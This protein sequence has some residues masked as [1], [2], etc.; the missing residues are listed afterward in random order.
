M[1]TTAKTLL[2]FIDPETGPITRI[3]SAPY[4]GLFKRSWWH[5]SAFLHKK[6]TGVTG[7]FKIFNQGSGGGWSPDKEESQVKAVVEAIERWSFFY[8]SSGQSA[9]LDIDSTTNGFA[10]LPDSFGSGPVKANA[11]CEALERWLLDRIWYNGD[12]FL[13]NFPWERTKAAALFGGHAKRLRVY[14]TET[15]DMEFPALS[16]KKVFFCL[17]LLETEYGGVLPG[18]ACGVDVNAVAEHAIIELYNHNL[19]FGKIKKLNPARLDSLIEA[20]LYY[21]AGSKSAG[22][23]VKAKIQI[24]R[25]FI[26]KIPELVFSAAITGPWNPEVNVYRVLLDGTVPFMADGV[27]RF[28]V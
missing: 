10:A 19:V 6:I 3:T 7:E 27:E 13:V 14:I 21:F 4:P 18:S 28:L 9:G 26:P 12:V 2:R 8:Y 22:E 1:T 11:Y 23:L 16:G 5:S 15:A 20:R 24:G 25:N 17:A